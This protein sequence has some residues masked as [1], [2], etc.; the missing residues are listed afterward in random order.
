[1]LSAV[2]DRVFTQVWIRIP[3][4]SY[5]ASHRLPSVIPCLSEADLAVGPLDG[6]ARGGT[7]PKMSGR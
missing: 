6:Q 2:D 5:S 3:F 1:M 4:Q 7:S